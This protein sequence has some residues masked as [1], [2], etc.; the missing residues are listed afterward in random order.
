MGCYK[1]SK[2]FGFLTREYG[3]A[4]CGFAFCS[5]CL[6]HRS[7]IPNK[8]TKEQK[9]CSACHKMLS[10]PEKC[11]RVYAPPEALQKRLDRL[12]NPGGTPVIVYKDNKKMTSLRRGLSV[13]D[14]KIVDRLEKLK[15]ER[16]EKENV[17]SDTE[18]A[19][20]L[21]KLK[22]ESSVVTTSSHHTVGTPFYQP[23]DPRKPLE[24]SRDLITAVQ[25]EVHL[26]AQQVTPEQDIAMRLARLRGEDPEAVKERLSK[27]R[28]PDPQQFLNSQTE[29]DLENMDLQ[30]VS[31]IIN[32]MGREL[33]SDAG[34][35]LEE[36]EG[37]KDLSVQLARIQALRKEKLEASAN[38]T[39]QDASEDDTGDED[40]RAAAL[41]RQLLKEQELE[42]R[43][44]LA[45]EVPNEN[46]SA[47][48]LE[49]L[50]WCVI[51]NDD[52]KIRCGGCGDDLYCRGCFKEFHQDEDPNEHQYKPYKQK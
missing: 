11:E 31:T 4:N 37:D 9:V 26:D 50:P 19:N 10:S 42:E 43:L 51:C 28:L 33:E 6:K 34:K 13:D 45:P 20:R 41:A 5:A 17:P 23:P 15:R 36:L 30:D 35:A 46:E 1:C 14:Q 52:A 22:G 2:E 21:S 39:D 32:K 27:P 8:G 44:G 7:V 16:K 40:E 38:K 47:E 18:I 29:Q 48:G 12:E 49:E 24:E 25:N 3:C